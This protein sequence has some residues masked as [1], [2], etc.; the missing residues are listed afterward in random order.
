MNIE[1]INN[2]V[3]NVNNKMTN[4]L[5]AQSQG[6]AQNGLLEKYYKDVNKCDIYQQ[7]ILR[8]TKN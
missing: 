2:V 6:Y 1:V 7:L 5:N 3:E 8:Y 4:M